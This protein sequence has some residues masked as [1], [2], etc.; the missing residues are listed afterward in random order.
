M[1]SS[2]IDDLNSSLCGNPGPDGRATHTVLLDNEVL[3]WYWRLSISRDDSQNGSTYR[4]GHVTLIRIDLDHDAFV[5][6]WMVL[7][8]VLFGVIGVD[9]V[10]HVGGNKETISNDSEEVFFGQVGF[11]VP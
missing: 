8:L 9:C 5:D 10:G 4:I 7:G 3:N 6:L 2:D 11:E 1:W